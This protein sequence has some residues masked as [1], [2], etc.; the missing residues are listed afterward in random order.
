MGAF[1][2]LA[3]MQCPHCRD[4]E[5]D[6][7]TVHRCHRCH[8]TLIDEHALLERLAAMQ[9]PEIPRPPEWSEQQRKTVRA[10]PE[11]SRTMET[12]AL[13]GIHVDRCAE[14]GMWFNEGELA[15]VLVKCQS[16]ELRQR[17]DVDDKRPA[18]K[19]LGV[20]GLLLYLFG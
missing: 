18:A 10:C 6:A 14:H 4:A 17:D 8:G 19:G 2:Q 12:V 15:A 3:R 13:F 9:L 5:L 1:R 7:S 20:L 11:C 16:R